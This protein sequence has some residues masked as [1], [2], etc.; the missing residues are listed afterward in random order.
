MA[1]A[2]TK[3]TEQSVEDFLNKID[4]EEVREDCFAIVQLMKKITGEPAKMWGPAIVGF[5]KYH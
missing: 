4:D 5:G 3:L 1:E 2:K